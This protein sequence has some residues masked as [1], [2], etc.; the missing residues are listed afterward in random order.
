[1]HRKFE[2]PR[3]EPK[4]KPKRRKGQL[5]KINVYSHDSERIY[6]GP[7]QTERQVFETDKTTDAERE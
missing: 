4:R 5:S 1:M 7:R 6:F 3:A 2:V